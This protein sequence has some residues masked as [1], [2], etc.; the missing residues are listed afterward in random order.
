MIRTFCPENH[1]LDECFNDEHDLFYNEHFLNITKHVKIL[2]TN[3]NK[4]YRCLKINSLF[5]KFAF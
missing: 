3:K 2:I 1:K 4:R 5:P